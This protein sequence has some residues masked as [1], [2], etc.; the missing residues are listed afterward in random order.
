[1]LTGK[2]GESCFSG[3]FPK[4]ELRSPITPVPLVLELWDFV[5]RC[6]IRCSQSMEELKRC[7]QPQLAKSA[8]EIGRKSWNMACVSHKGDDNGR[9]LKRSLWAKYWLL[10]VH[11]FWDAYPCEGIRLWNALRLIEMPTKE[12]GFS[13]YRGGTFRF[14]SKKNFFK[15][16]Y[17]TNLPIIMIIFL[18]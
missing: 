8:F 7:K 17:Y 14:F 18:Q 13:I 5:L 2:T 1:M 15:A 6:S 3:F 4:L 12:P 9:N 11:I 16:K 10:D